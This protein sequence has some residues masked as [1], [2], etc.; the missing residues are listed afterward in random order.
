MSDVAV[1]TPYRFVRSGLATQEAIGNEPH[2]F[3]KMSDAAPYETSFDDWR[4]RLTRNLTRR[5]DGRWEPLTRTHPA[6]R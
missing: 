5:S 4:E 3:P 2:P 1:E 6:E